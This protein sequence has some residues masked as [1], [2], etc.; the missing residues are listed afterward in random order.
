MTVI[1]AGACDTESP[2]LIHTDCSDGWPLNSVD[3]VSRMSAGVAPNSRQPGLLDRAAERPGHR[4]EAVAHAEHRHP[5]LEQRRVERGGA[6]LVD[7]RRPA[8][9]DD[10]R[11]LLGEHLGHRHRVRHDLAE[12]RTPRG[13]AARSAGRTGRRSRRR[14]RGARRGAPARP[15]RRPRGRGRR[16]GAW[17]GPCGGRRSRGQGYRRAAARPAST[18]RATRRST[19]NDRNGTQP[20]SMTSTIF[21]S[22]QPTLKP[23]SAVATR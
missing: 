19:Q 22:V 23:S 11:G 21:G 17:R 10:R 13:P 14:A 4:L 1:P 7:R 16:D 8:G 6:L 18:S 5:G 3:E 20:A 2:W 15:P 9:Q 12:A